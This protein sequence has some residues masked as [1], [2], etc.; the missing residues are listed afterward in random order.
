MLSPSFLRLSGLL[1]TIW[2][3]GRKSLPENKAKFGKHTCKMDKENSYL[4]TWV[5]MW[6]GESL[7]LLL[8]RCWLQKPVH[9]LELLKLVKAGGSATGNGKDPASNT[10]WNLSSPPIP[11]S[12]ISYPLGSLSSSTPTQTQ[13]AS[14]SPWTRVG[15]GHDL[16]QLCCSCFLFPEMAS[17]YP[18]LP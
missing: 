13:N 16:E 1:K 18:F 10:T 6:V 9:S 8:T 3:L 5:K 15:V 7:R 17:G 2:Q 11:T 14:P 12:L 4:E